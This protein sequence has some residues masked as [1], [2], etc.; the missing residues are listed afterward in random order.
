MSQTGDESMPVVSRRYLR[1]LRFPAR[2]VRS[3]C[4]TS[5]EAVRARNGGLLS[6]LATLAIAMAVPLGLSFGHAATATAA[7]ESSS[8]QEGDA[9]PDPDEGSDGTAAEAADDAPDESSAINYSDAIEK[10]QEWTRE[11]RNMSNP[12][13]TGD[14]DK[15]YV[16]IR[17]AYNAL[18]SNGGSLNGGKDLET[19][20]KALDLRI[21]RAADPS[22]Q[23]DAQ[24]IRDVL[25]QVRREIARAGGAIT[26]APMKQ[27]F[28]RDY[29]REVL[30]VLKKL[31]DNNW[32]ARSFAISLMPDLE[33]VPSSFGVKRIEVYE[34][35]ATLLAQIVTDGKNQPDSIHMRAAAEISRLLKKTDL[36]P[37][38]QLKLAKALV[39]E[40]TRNDTE[41]AY[42]LELV[43]ALSE[44]DQAREAVGKHVP[45]ALMSLVQIMSDNTRHVLVRCEAAKGIGRAGFDAQVNFEPLAWK[46]AQLSVQAGVF[47]NQNKNNRQLQW[48]FSLAGADLYFA[49]HHEDADFKGGRNPQGMLNR[50]S[51]S[52]VVSD[53]YQ[54]VLKIAPR[55]WFGEPIPQADLVAVNNWV[56][57]NVPANMT[58]DAN[59]PPLT[60]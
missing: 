23:Q 12:L 44:I 19:V 45:T 14:Y 7:D 46:T 15:D 51:R 40:L 28:R 59:A 41:I 16:K 13:L 3:L 33:V 1:D 29:C 2:L 53:A 56:N 60:K 17:S 20:Q 25:D 6:G 58:W 55:M 21:L 4:S 57:A 18:L 37:L 47:Y 43:R 22:I 34:P 39:S 32:E 48:V 30:T 50:A 42:Q 10:Q 9:K 5:A 35:V 54:Q 52:E 11:L 36:T 24:Q 26:N 31:L 38:V 27:R 8:Q 49:F